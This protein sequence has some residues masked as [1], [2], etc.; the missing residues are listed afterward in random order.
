MQVHFHVKATLGHHVQ[1]ANLEQSYI[2]LEQNGCRP[3][4]LLSN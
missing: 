3:A 2:H 4:L 1:T